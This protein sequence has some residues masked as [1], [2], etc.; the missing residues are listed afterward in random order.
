[1]LA[2]VHQHAW[3]VRDVAMRLMR[4]LT[5]TVP[6][7]LFHYK[8]EKLTI[9]KVHAHKSDAPPFRPDSLSCEAR[10]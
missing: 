5:Q 9:F 3:A 6:Q 2:S 8:F 1:M 4:E 10:A 7:R